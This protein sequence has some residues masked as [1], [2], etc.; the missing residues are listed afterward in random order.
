MDFLV[1]LTPP[2]FFVFFFVFSIFPFFSLFCLFH[3]SERARG[4]EVAFSCLTGRRLL[5][6]SRIAVLVAVLSF[7]AVVM[8]P[9]TLASKIVRVQA[10]KMNKA[11]G[12]K[13]FAAA[14]DLNRKSFWSSLVC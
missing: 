12:C 2:P 5:T 11:A 10:A 8:L 4:W 1:C 6:C 14:T 13:K 3:V 9:E 7:A